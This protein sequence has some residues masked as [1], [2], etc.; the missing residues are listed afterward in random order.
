LSTSV[1]IFTAAC[2]CASVQVISADLTVGSTPSTQVWAN[3]V[4]TPCGIVTRSRILVLDIML[5][6]HFVKIGQCSPRMPDVLL[7]YSSLTNMNEPNT[8]HPLEVRLKHVSTAIEVA[9]YV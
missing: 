8:P 4:G 1:T 3:L 2:I 7:G 9:V 5:P 6:I